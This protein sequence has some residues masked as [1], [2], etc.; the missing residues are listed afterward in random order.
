MI[1]SCEVYSMLVNYAKI[2]MLQQVTPF[3][4]GSSPKQAREHA[5]HPH[6]PRTDAVER[7][8]DVEVEH[9]VAILVR[10]GR[11]IIDDVSNLGGRSGR[12]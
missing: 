6:P 7:G 1:N 11:V 8:P 4:P 10:R 5:S 2:R 9:R 3:P 12:V